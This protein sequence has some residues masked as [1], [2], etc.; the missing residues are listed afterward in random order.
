M[1]EP[2]P[3]PDQEPRS[4]SLDSGSG[5]MPKGWEGDLPEHLSMSDDAARLDWI[6]RNRAKIDPHYAGS[7]TGTTVILPLQNGADYYGE[8]VREAIDQAMKGAA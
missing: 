5:P 2:N 8:T 1:T 7:S 4:Y 6:E 3:N